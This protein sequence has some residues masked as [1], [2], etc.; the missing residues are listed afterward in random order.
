MN[1]F[2]VCVRAGKET[3][4]E[5]EAQGKQHRDITEERTGKSPSPEPWDLPQ[6]LSTPRRSGYSSCHHWDTAD[7][8][9]LRGKMMLTA[10]QHN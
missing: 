2:A 4:A 5:L 8:C 10:S 6:T 7:A 1:S 9:G 3:G